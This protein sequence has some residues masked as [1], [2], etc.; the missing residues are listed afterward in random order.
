MHEALDNPTAICFTTVKVLLIIMRSHARSNSQC[1]LV[2]EPEIRLGLGSFFSF[3]DQHAL[4][5]SI[6]CMISGKSLL[7]FDSYISLL[8]DQP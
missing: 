7:G 4:N 8:V 6:L 5:I 3:L 2:I 1:G